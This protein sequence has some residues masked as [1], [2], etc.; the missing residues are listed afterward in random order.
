MIKVV[1]AILQND[2]KILIAKKKEGKPLAGFYEFPGGKVEEGE[3]PED[4]LVR[5]LM[6]EMSIKVTVKDYVGKS[7]YDY[8]NGKVIE[9]LGYTAEIIEGDIVLTDHDEYR[10]VTLEE[11]CNYNIAPADIPLI[12]KI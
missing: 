1:A 5:E 3:N 7:I 12:S 10:W 4:S 8:G 9:L 2:D 11:V 6:E